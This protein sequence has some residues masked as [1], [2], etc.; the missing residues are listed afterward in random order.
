MNKKRTIREELARLFGLKRPEL[1]SEV[2]T[3]TKLQCTYD[4]FAVAKSTRDGSS[5]T[6][7]G[8]DTGSKSD[9]RFN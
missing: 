1:I 8:A 6:W 9:L 7:A 2:I 5:Y 3:S 4:T